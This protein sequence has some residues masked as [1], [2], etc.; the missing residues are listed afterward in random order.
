M[1]ILKGSGNLVKHCASSVQQDVGDIHQPQSCIPPCANPSV[2]SAVSSLP[3][4][5][6]GSSIDVFVYLDDWLVLGSLQ[7]DSQAN[8]VQVFGMLGYLGWNVSG[9]KSSLTTSQTITISVFNLTLFPRWFSLQTSGSPNSLLI[10][11]VF[12]LLPSCQPSSVS[13][14]LA[15]NKLYG[16]PRSLSTSHVATTMSF[17]CEYCF[18]VSEPGLPNPASSPLFPLF[19]GDCRTLWQI[20]SWLHA[21][22]TS[23]GFCCSYGFHPTYSFCSHRLYC[24]GHNTAVCFTIHTCRPLG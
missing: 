10:Y 13:S 4:S 15:G 2:I 23:C 8:K 18:S 22:P 11:I 6:C 21:G 14:C 9:Q 20:S 5:Q 19:C 24:C 1:S 12:F 16:P 3:L 17:H 7:V